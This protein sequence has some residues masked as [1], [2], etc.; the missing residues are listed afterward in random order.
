MSV[1][2][3]RLGPGQSGRLVYQVLGQD[4]PILNPQNIRYL[5]PPDATAGESGNTELAA[6]IAGV[7]L[8]TSVT[9]V[10]LSAKILKEVAR[11]H[12]KLDVVS[13]LAANIDA[14]TTEILQRVERID[15]RVAENNLRHA[16]RHVFDRAVDDDEIDVR[17]LA[18]LADD[19]A[20]FIETLEAP[21][22]LNCSVR[23]ATDVRDNLSAV[24]SFLLALRTLIARHHNRAVNGDPT[25]AVVVA[26]EMDYLTWSFPFSVDGAIAYDRI[27]K[28]Y[29]AA[30]EAVLESVNT[31][32][33]WSDEEDVQFFR[34]LLQEKLAGGL[35]DV[36]RTQ[37]A[38]SAILYSNL[39]DAIFNETDTETVSTQIYSFAS[40]WLWKTD[41]GLLW[42]ANR[43][44]LG[45]QNGYANAFWF[46]LDGEK[47]DNIAMIDVACST[48]DAET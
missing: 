45:I 36:F 10:A 38:S 32:F 27:A 33:T 6:G 30:L 47:T 26:P 25:R 28:H 21:I 34:D 16:M 14:K 3:E 40:A 43:E 8:I 4:G 20:A 48:A 5:P 7:N 1:P 29:V 9:N 23:F 42:R 24:T 15:A 35:D 37:L 13:A 31:R 2:F 44:L 19:L 12:E 18:S 41:G 22:T 39:P 11:L 46:H 17:R